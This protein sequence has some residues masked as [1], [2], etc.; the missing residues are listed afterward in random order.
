MQYNGGAFPHHSTASA[1][2]VVIS[3]IPKTEAPGACGRPGL[4][5][6]KVD[7]R[8]CQSLLAAVYSGEQIEITSAVELF[9]GFLSR[10]VLAVAVILN[11][12]PTVDVDSTGME[13][14][15]MTP[16]NP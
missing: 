2:P 14:L 7:F 15:M 10:G 1:L 11:L 12:L 16:F 8:L 5:G 4:R 13:V 6:R 3:H 9:N